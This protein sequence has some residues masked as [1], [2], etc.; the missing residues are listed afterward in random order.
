MYVED[1]SFSKDN[2]GVEY[3]TNEQKKSYKNVSGRPSQKQRRCSAENICKWCAKMSSQ[4]SKD[5]PVT[6]NRG[7]EMHF[8]R[9]D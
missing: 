8:P 3:I 2:S 6:Q 4:A 1:F 7:N 9:G 5:A